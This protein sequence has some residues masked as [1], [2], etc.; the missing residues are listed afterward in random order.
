MNFVISAFLSLGA[1]ELWN[2]QDA[3][4]WHQVCR[5]VVFD[6]V[7]DN[8]SQLADELAISDDVQDRQTLCV[9]SYNVSV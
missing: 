2:M 9:W 1:Y 5:F 6:D 3:F 7:A 4:L 8:K